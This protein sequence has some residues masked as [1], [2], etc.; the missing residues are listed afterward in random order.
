MIHW[1]PTLMFE[2]IELSWD[3]VYLFEFIMFIHDYCM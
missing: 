3:V 1:L 2:S